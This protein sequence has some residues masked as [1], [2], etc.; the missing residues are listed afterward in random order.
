VPGDKFASRAGQKGVLSRLWPAADMPFSES[1][2]TPDILFNPHGFPSRMTIGMMLESMAG[3]AG[4]MHGVKQDSSP[5]KFSEDHRA[6]DYFGDQLAAAGYAYHGTE[7]MFSGYYGTELQVD[8]FLGIVYYQRLRHMVSD[9]HQV[10]ARGPINPLTHQPV[11][12]RKVHGGIRLGEMERDALL[13]HGAAFLVQDRLLRCSDESKSLV[14][15]KCGSL[16]TPMISPPIEGSLADAK[17][18]AYCRN[19]NDGRDVDVITIPYVLKYLT[20]ELAAM[21]IR[22]TITTKHVAW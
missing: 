3:K 20:N 18:H 9:K 4:A 8:I 12:G 10:R 14:C 13:A 21:N 17:R 15:T 16:L 7:T 11:H 2:L 5:F 19:C 1:G 6:V 22:T